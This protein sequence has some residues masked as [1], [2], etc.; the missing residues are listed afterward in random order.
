M[1]YVLTVQT[2]TTSLEWE[3]IKFIF[4]LKI[5]G[6][7]QQNLFHR[8]NLLRQLLSARSIITRVRAQLQQEISLT[9]MFH[10]L[11]CAQVIV[12]LYDAL[13]P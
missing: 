7:I 2:V 8:L 1:P 5:K 4:I 12:C 6:S 13:Q 3:L 10:T 11:D 9:Q